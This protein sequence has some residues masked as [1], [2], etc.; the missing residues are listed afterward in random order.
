MSRR[1]TPTI[2]ARPSAAAISI[3]S[4][5]ARWSSPSRTRPIAM[6][7]GEISNVVEIGVRLPHRPARRRARRRKEAVRGRACRTRGA[8]AQG[9][10]RTGVR[11]RRRSFPEPGQQGRRQLQRRR[12]GTEAVQAD[13]HRAAHAGG[14]CHRACWLRRSCSTRC[15]APMRS[16]A[17]STPRRSKPDRAS[18]WRRVCWQHT[19]GAGASA[20]RGD[21]AG[22]RAPGPAAGGGARRRRRARTSWPR[23]RRPPTT[24]PGCRRCDRCRAC[25][26]AGQPR[27]GVDA[28]LQADAAKLPQWLGVDLGSEGYAV[29]RLSAVKNRPP[30]RRRSRS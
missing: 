25:E 28:V 9:T 4:A 14:R 7:V 29:V 6:K 20:G 11:G 13:G 3:S 8:S 27:P 23:C 22:A 2:P 12:Q 10:G 16:R 5:A 21:G 18:S 19:P 15:S 26:P 24:R 30:M 1:R 17:S